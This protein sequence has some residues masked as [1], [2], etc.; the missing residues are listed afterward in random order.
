MTNL[1]WDE[2]FAAALLPAFLWTFLCTFLCTFFGSM[3]TLLWGEPL[4]LHFAGVF[5]AIFV[6]IFV[7][8]FWLNDDPP[9]G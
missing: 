2:P 1:L 5:M 3:M 7:Y 8:I 4:Q 6:D 9:L